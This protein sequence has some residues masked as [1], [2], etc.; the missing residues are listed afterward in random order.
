LAFTDEAAMA[1]F[2]AAFVGHFHV[3]NWVKGVNSKPLLG[4]AL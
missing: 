4:S 1:V 2:H 3:V